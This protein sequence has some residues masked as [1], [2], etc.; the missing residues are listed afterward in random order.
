MHIQG[1]VQ[2]K[3]KTVEENLVSSLF[4]NVCFFLSSSK[5]SSIL[6]PLRFHTHWC[7]IKLTVYPKQVD[8]GKS[9][10]KNS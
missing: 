7:Q 10:N 3:K 5:R 2:P 8:F 4:N 6:L 1:N 9:Y